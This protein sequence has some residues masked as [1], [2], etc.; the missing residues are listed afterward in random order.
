MQTDKNYSLD[1]LRTIGVPPIMIFHF[2]WI[3]NIDVWSNSLP[4]RLSNNLGQFAVEIFFVISGYLI[5]SQLHLSSLNEKPFS[6]WIFFVKRITKTWPGYLVLL[7]LF[8]CVPAFR[9]G[10]FPDWAILLS[11]TQNLGM[12]RSSISY[13][14]HVCVEEHFYLTYALLGPALIQAK[15]R[16][17][18]V[19]LILFVL[20]AGPLLRL[21]LWLPHAGNP[22]THHLYNRLIFYPTW[23]RLDGLAFGVGLSYLH[24]F[25]PELWRSL[26]RLWPLLVAGFLASFLFVIW[27]DEAPRSLAA[28]S[29]R[30]TACSASATLLCAL[31]LIFEKRLSRFRLPGVRFVSQVCYAHYLVHVPAFILAAAFLSGIS[32][33][34]YSVPGAA[35]AF[36]FVVILSLLFYY[37]V[38]TPFMRL[39]RTERN[40]IG[41]PPAAV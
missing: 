37:F 6:R 22:A 40:H 4:L 7:I 33:E 26:G 3:G 20:L 2:L 31:G 5:S 23:A 32:I 8:F 18:Y 36:A 30:F 24:H 13:T 25:K 34:R 19:S 10:A 16:P 15:R 28:V 29:L 1:L 17:A 27:L 9:F 11:F 21:Y 38:E 14:W 35:V 41:K 12:D 39:R